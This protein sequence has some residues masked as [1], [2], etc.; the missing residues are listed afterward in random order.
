MIGGASSECHRS[1]N[2]DNKKVYEADCIEHGDRFVTLFKTE[3][4]DKK[5]LY[6]I[7]MDMASGWGGECITVKETK[8]YDNI[9]D[10]YDMSNFHRN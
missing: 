7:G 6:E 8:D 1:W 2:E 10:V 3:E 4:T 9:D 5:K